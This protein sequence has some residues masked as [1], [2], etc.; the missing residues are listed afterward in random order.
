MDLPI[1][2]KPPGDARPGRRRARSFSCAR[3]TPC[4]GNLFDCEVAANIIFIDS[5]LE[6]KT[7]NTF[8]KALPAE[9]LKIKIWTSV[10]SE[11]PGRHQESLEE[12][13]QGPGAG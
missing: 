11:E 1:K 3:Q 2:M 6:A 12:G 4:K 13:R 8:L 10:S 9:Y 7:P 5:L